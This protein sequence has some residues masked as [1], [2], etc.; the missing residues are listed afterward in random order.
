MRLLFGLITLL[1]PPLCARSFPAGD[2]VQV[3]LRAGSLGIQ[4]NETDV[5][6]LVLW[7]GLGDAYA[8]AGMLE[9]AELIKGVHPGIFVHSIYVEENLDADQ[10]AGFFGNVDV[11]LEAVAA[12]LASIDE[13]S[14]GFDAIGFSQGAYNE[15]PIHNLL[16]FGSQHMGVADLPLCRPT[17]FMCQA[18]RRAARAGVYSAWAQ[19]NIIQAQYYRDPDQLPAY[20]SKNKFLTSINNEIPTTVNQTY[21][22]NLA[23]LSNLV[24]ILFSEDKTVVPKESAWFGSYAPPEEDESDMI[25]AIRAKTILPMRLQPTYLADTFG[26][27][28]LDE[29]GAVVLE[30]CEGEHMQIAQECWEPLVRRYVGGKL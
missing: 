10:R 14:R 3:P 29:R 18:A 11:Q 15:P 25:S 26:L 16:T 5:R 23:T 7:H 13:L 24:L 30:I 8:S 22:A 9:F 28:K 6:P 21:A 17:D 4:K 20:F 27:R 19:T 1:I 2:S 12:Q